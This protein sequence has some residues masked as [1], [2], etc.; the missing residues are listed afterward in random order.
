MLAFASRLVCASVPGLQISTETAPAGGWAQIKI[1]AVPPMA[2]SSGEVVLNLDST[3]FGPG[4]QVGLFGANGDASGVATTTGSQIDVRFVS[5][6]GGIGQLAGLPVLVFTVPVLATAAGRTVAVTATSPDSS[7]TVWSGSVTVNGALSVAKIPAGVGVVPAGTV[8][9]ITGTGFT[10]S[11]TVSIDGVAIASTQFV[12]SQELDVT[13]GGAA[14]LVGK[15]ARVTDGG[16][17]FDYYC[18]QPNDPVNLPSLSNSQPL[19][20][21]F[22]STGWDVGVLEIGGIVAIQNPNTATVHL[23]VTSVDV[24]CGPTQGGAATFAI[25]PGSW[26]AFYSIRTSDTI[27]SDLPVRVVSAAYNVSPGFELPSTALPVDTSGTP[28]PVVTL[29]PSSLALSWQIGASEPPATRSVLVSYD[30][31]DGAVVQAQ[32]TAGQSWLSVATAASG[33]LVTGLTVTVNPA[34][35]AVGTYQ[36]TVVVTPSVGPATTL[37][38]TLTVTAAAVPTISANP[39]SLTF[40][41]PAFNAPP[42]S[43]TLTLTSD[44]GPAAFS[45]SPDYWLKIS[46]LSGTTPATLTVTWDPAVTSQIYYSQLSTPGSILISG[47]GNAVTVA[48]TFN[49]TGVQTFQTYLAT[50]GT[51]PN[52]LLFTAQAGSAPQTQTIN[53]DPPGM[54]GATTDQPWMSATA[55]T[56]FTVAVTVN[57][58]G[59]AQGVYHGTVTIGEPGL[60]PCTVP[61]VLGVWSTAPPLTISKGSFTFV[62]AVGE[63]APAYQTAEVDAGGIPIPFTIA[64]GG[65]WLEVGDAYSAP[66]PT[67]IVVG[68]LNTMWY[69]PGEY[70]G[71]FTLQSPGGSVYVPVTLLV[72]P[73]AAALPVV[74]QVVNAASGMAD[75]VSPG[76]IVSVR[77]YGV[78]A[79]AVG[80]LRLDPAGNL[81]SEISGLEVT[82]D[83]KA[84]P[85][86]YTS[87]SQT[88]LIVPYEVAGQTSTMMQVSYTTASGTYRT[89]AWVLPVVGTAPGVFSVD[90]TGTGQAAVVNQD[91][92]VNSAANPAARGSV[93][94]IYA[95]GEGQTSPAGV[96]GSVTQSTTRTPLLPVTVT[97]GGIT[98]VVQYAGSAPGEVAGLLQVNAVVPQGVEPGSAVPVTVSVGGVA[99]QSGVVIVVN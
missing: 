76:E 81:I 62:Q 95:T 14:E 90:A 30:N 27:A 98:A 19:F 69:P 74:S 20:P 82:F 58:A 71:S 65:N 2:I 68:L 55:P 3:A 11:T 75:G 15:R 33:L 46:P 67:Q 18:F 73:G 99:S 87:T 97:I 24:C 83:G 32:V 66:T 77:G 49:V 10:G 38:V 86:I 64:V 31:G 29:T 85:L 26:T 57:P 12:S 1:Y 51:G 47:P 43:Q 50:S 70:D 91:G 48:A 13:L 59:L 53:V 45:V 89:P 80:G 35:L 56:T 60:A 21:L 92:S 37:P 22:A 88:N 54:L 72:E 36:G 8:V 63:A 42:Y 44:T 93:V 5:P 96:T 6:G 7:V 61:V 52:G 9:P 39:A 16:A 28:L 78:G 94:S 84:A 40:T 23:T 25:P 41:A 17:E 4:T 79:S 34:Q